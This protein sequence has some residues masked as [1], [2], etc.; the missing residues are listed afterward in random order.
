MV[1]T[2][3]TTSGEVSTISAASF[4]RYEMKVYK[5]SEILT[6]KEKLETDTTA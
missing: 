5:H 6:T 1:V 2:T 3:R 4:Y